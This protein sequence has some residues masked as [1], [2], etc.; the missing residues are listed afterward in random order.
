MGENIMMKICRFCG[1]QVFGYPFKIDLCILKPTYITIYQWHWHFPQNTNICMHKYYCIYHKCNLRFLCTEAIRKHTVDKL[2][3]PEVTCRDSN[4][5]S[6]PNLMFVLYYLIGWYI[7]NFSFLRLHFFI[8]FSSWEF[9]DL[10]FGN[11]PF[12]GP[13]LS[14]D[15]YI[16]WI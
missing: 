16:S 2:K 8:Y 11:K 15:L 3:T 12:S 5:M 10:R 9:I 13:S 7:R 1:E 14:W 6:W 4:K